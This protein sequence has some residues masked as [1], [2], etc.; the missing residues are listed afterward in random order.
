M[1]DFT[2][3]V[4][5]AAP[6]SVAD[7]L[8]PRYA[9][10]FKQEKQGL[11]ATLCEVGMR[12]RRPLSAC[13]KETFMFTSTTQPRNADPEPHPSS[14]APRPFGLRVRV[15]LDTTQR[16]LFGD[17]GPILNNPYALA[18]IGKAAGIRGIPFEGKTVVLKEQVAQFF[19][20]TLRT[21][22]NYLEQN[23]E[24]L[25][26]DGYAVLKGN[27]L[28]QLTL[29]I[30]GLDVPETDFGNISRAPQRGWHK[31]GRGL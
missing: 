3:G 24:E 9:L 4:V 31:T 7:A 23:A 20:V 19:E 26:R 25:A 13:R 17:D 22:E 12:G 1:I 10:F 14:T 21:V 11:D 29:A 16:F 15:S 5:K 28:K 27:R 18:E 30:E 8:A 2:S 6:R